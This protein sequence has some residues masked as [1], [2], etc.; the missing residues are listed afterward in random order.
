LQ[1]CQEI[2]NFFF[3][4]LFHNGKVHGLG[5]HFVDHGLGL[6]H[7]GPARQHE[8]ET[9]RERLG[10]RFGLPVLAGGGRDGEGQCGA[11]AT[12]LTGAQGAAERPGDL[13]EVAAV[14]G[15]SGGMF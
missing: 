10:W 9:T 12:G 4:D 5:P 14:V 7:G 11:L 3:C 8:R 6:I 15:L 13:G 2:L 1:K